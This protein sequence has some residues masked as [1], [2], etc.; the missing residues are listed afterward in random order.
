M[1]I[2]LFMYLF[3]LFYIAAFLGTKKMVQIGKHFINIL[4]NF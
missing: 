3:N 1:I 4:D 2:Y